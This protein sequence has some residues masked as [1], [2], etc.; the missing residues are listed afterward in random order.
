MKKLCKVPVL[1]TV[2]LGLIAL[3]FCDL[4]KI[5]RKLEDIKSDLTK[6]GLTKPDLTKSDLINSDLPKSYRIQSLTKSEQIN[7]NNIK[8]SEQSEHI[9]LDV[10]SGLRTCGL[11][12]ALATSNKLNSLVKIKLLYTL[13]NLNSN[14]LQYTFITLFKSQN[15]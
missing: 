12:S 8:Q 4:N 6:S 2:C 7:Q 5:N 9:K 13:K 14:L 1:A 10:C 15:K 3:A 11:K